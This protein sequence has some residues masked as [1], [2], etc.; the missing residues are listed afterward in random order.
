MAY[1]TMYSFWDDKRFPGFKKS[2][3]RIYQNSRSTYL[4]NL[5]LSSSSRDKDMKMISTF[6]HD[7]EYYYRSLFDLEIVTTKNSSTI[8]EQLKSI[9]VV[10]I[11]PQ[12]QRSFYGLTYRKQIS[13]NPDIQ[14]D[15]GLDE[16][17]F[18]QLAVSH[19]LG[20]IL[21]GFWL[22]DEVVSQEVAEK[23]AYRKANKKRPSYEYRRDKA[24]FNYRPYLTNYILYGELQ[25]FAIQFARSIP[26]IDCTK[27]DSDE[28]VLLKLVRR[29]FSP[30]FIKNIRLD[31]FHTPEKMDDFIIMLACM[32][33]IRDATYQVL[34][35]N[36]TSK[37]LN[38]NPYISSF[39]MSA[40]NSCK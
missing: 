30:D 17:A 35:S 8:L 28:D 19:E 20:H 5:W 29:S 4:K 14:A 37:D 6:M 13:I 18:K 34:G 31:Y 33:R 12:D 26:C 10:K 23:V 40:K 39:Q 16:E 9:D 1:E 22:V 25:E 15:C 3:N 24:I 11:L 27:Q 36:R 38:V 7:L 32:G 2:L 21:N